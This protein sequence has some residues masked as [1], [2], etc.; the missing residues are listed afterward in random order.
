MDI[1]KKPVFYTEL[2]YLIG[3][4]CTAFATALMTVADF[5]LSMIAA[6]SYLLH[7]KISEFLPFFS[8]GMAA[9]TYQ[10]ILLI[11]M[12]ILVRRFRISYFFSFV[13]GVLY[14]LILDL[15]MLFISTIPADH[16]AVRIALYVFGLL[17]SGVGVALMFRT[18]IS[19]AVYE[20]FVKELA[21]HYSV[22]VSRFKMGFD[23]TSCVFAIV[24]SFSF[25]GFLNF[26]GI[27][28][29]TVV[30]ALVNGL[31][32]GWIGKGL[33]K[34]FTFSDGLKLRGLFQK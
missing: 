16:M 26:V 2:A 1:K 32:I 34:R 13:T 5:G 15:S 19:P 17:C 6:P 33:D 29:G 18:Y 11:S 27:N 8:F 20:L 24:L 7:L 23:Y 12:M 14:G 30:C 10:A 28:V 21:A 4:V 9:Y 31:L 25:F 22:P 3:L